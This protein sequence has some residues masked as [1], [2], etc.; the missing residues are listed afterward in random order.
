MVN[1]L[2]LE[3]NTKLQINVQG[4]DGKLNCEFVGMPNDQCILA[5]FPDAGIAD[6]VSENV[7]GSLNGKLVYG[8]PVIVRYVH[9]GKVFGFESVVMG[10]ITTPVR[11][12]FINY[13]RVIE[14]INLRR[15]ERLFCLLPARLIVDNESTAG[16]F[17]SDS[18]SGTIMD[19]CK[20]GC[21]F[22]MKAENVLDEKA[23]PKDCDAELEFLLPGIGEP[24]V[25]SINIKSLSQ[26]D[27]FAFIGV[28]FTKIKAKT[29]HCLD[30][31]IDSNVKYTQEL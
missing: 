6:T 5:T 3:I 7:S 21:R 28:Q 18:M 17:T 26:R 10:S 24:N 23:L 8:K 22:K 30:D 29:R 2:N 4:L 9:N 11:L 20:A 16:T 19:V 1:N 13:P 27:G 25:V 14:K 15:Q 12:L 31:Y